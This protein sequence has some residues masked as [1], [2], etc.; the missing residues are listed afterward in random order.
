M[1]KPGHD[2]LAEAGETAPMVQM[3]A[4]VIGAVFL[5]IGLA[6]FIPGI[7]TGFDRLEWAGP[8]S[9]ALLLDLFAVS[10]LHNTAHIAAGIAGLVL[11][12]APGTARVYL[13]CG[14]VLCSALWLYGVLIDHRGPLNVVPVNGAVNWLH[15]GLAAAMLGSGLVLGRMTARPDPV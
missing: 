5:L 9:G 1:T 8:H 13:V 12:R 6:G 15:L 11:A 7:T 4:M 2:H 3:A 10:V 14:G